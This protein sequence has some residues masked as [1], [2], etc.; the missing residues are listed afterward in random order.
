MGR[1]QHRRLDARRHDPDRG[2]RA[3]RR[4]DR[5]EPA[6][7]RQAGVP[8]LLSGRHDHRLHPSVAGQRRQDLEGGRQLAADG[9]RH[10]PRRV[11]RRPPAAR[12]RSRRSRTTAAT[13]RWATSTATPATC[14]PRHWSTTRWRRSACRSAR[15]STSGSPGRCGRGH[16]DPG[17]GARQGVEGRPHVPG[18]GAQRALAASIGPEPGAEEIDQHLGEGGPAGPQHQGR[19]GPVGA[20]G[21]VDDGQAGRSSSGVPLQPGGHATVQ[22]LADNVPQVGPVIEHPHSVPVRLNRRAVIFCRYRR[23]SVPFERK[24]LLSGA[25]RC[26]PVGGRP[27]GSPLTG[28]L[29]KHP[30]ADDGPSAP[31][32]GP[33]RVEFHERRGLHNRRS[34]HGDSR[35]RGPAARQRLREGQA[36]RRPLHG[37][38]D[39][40]GRRCPTARSSTSTGAPAPAADRSGSTTRRP[41]PPPWR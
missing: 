23:K 19:A 40:A 3:V 20:A 34:G 38:A 15:S 32:P 10:R 33:A 8:G 2:R 24:R 36:R 22:V 4:H 29:V 14:T 17:E 11:R 16:R 7:P 31:H 21:R 28:G 25:H 6:L 18:A 13:W 12:P 39:R 30:T 27:S 5:R 26:P 9:A 41:A 35:R 37:R 1:R